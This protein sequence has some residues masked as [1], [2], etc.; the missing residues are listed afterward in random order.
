MNGPPTSF[1]VVIPARQAAA[2]VGRALAGLL[3]LQPGPFDLRVHVQDGGST[4]GTLEVVER[5]RRR[6]ERGELPDAERRRVTVASRRDAG[7]YD[8]VACAL[9]ACAPGPDE[10]LTWLGSDDVLVP[11]AL[12]T[13]QAAMTQ[14]PALRW[15]TGTPQVADA[16]GA[17]F[18]PWRVP[19]YARRELRAG[20]HDGRALP[21]VMQ[22]G[23]F[24]RA[25]LHLEAGGLRR[26]LRL[27]GDYDL[28]RRFA[29]TDELAMLSTPLAIWTQRSGQASGDS[30]AYY[31]EVDRVLA[32]DVPEPPEAVLAAGDP[33]RVLRLERFPGGGFAEVGG[34]AHLAAPVEV[35]ER[36]TA[37]CRDAPAFRVEGRAVVRLPILSPGRYRVA[38]RLRCGRGRALLRLRAGH[39]ALGEE[40]LEGGWPH[41]TRVIALDADFPGAAPLL[42]LE[43]SA[44]TSGPG[45]GSLRS[46]L[47]AAR[48]GALPDVWLEDLH[49]VRAPPRPRSTQE[50]RSRSTAPGPAAAAAPPDR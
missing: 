10:V 15:V 28:W 41:R 29:R 4:D 14:L 24:W 44:S 18:T 33:R 21:F 37:S 32:E 6:V 16:G 50:P 17:W 48:G 25:S 40:W 43:L 12:A 1:L 26:D 30:A 39:Q 47:G 31:A 3:E 45:A 7:I 5:W 9:D 13:V 23:T 27:A 35:G 34:E 2:H 8:A 42:R 49:L 19:G 20:L 11:G 38:L 36:D 22:E 46:L